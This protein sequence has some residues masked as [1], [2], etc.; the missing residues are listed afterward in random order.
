MSTGQ[1]PALMSTDMDQGTHQRLDH[2][3]IPSVD[4]NTVRV[5]LEWERDRKNKLCTWNLGQHTHTHQNISTNPRALIDGSLKIFVAFSAFP[6]AQPPH[7][8]G[9][10]R[11][12]DVPI[13]TCRSEGTA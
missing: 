13:T 6:R 10:T 3:A 11:K 5:E 7:D 2:T 9:P 4:P 1:L 12:K 8:L